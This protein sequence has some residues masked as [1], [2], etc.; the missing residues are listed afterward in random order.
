MQ[1]NQENNDWIYTIMQQRKYQV[2]LYSSGKMSQAGLNRPIK[3]MIW[4]LNIEPKLTP[5][6]FV[7]TPGICT[8]LF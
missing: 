2:S 5:G 7:T 3:Y 1:Q 4:T 6:Q 8:K